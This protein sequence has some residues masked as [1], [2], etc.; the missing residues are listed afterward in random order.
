MNGTGHSASRSLGAIAVVGFLAVHASAVRPGTADLRL[1]PRPGD[2][3][4]WRA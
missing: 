1:S 3:R 2:W 4:S